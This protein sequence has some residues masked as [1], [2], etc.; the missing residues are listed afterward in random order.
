MCKLGRRLQRSGIARRVFC[1]RIRKIAESVTGKFP[2]GW[3][4]VTQEGNEGSHPREFV[5]VN[6]DHGQGRCHS[7]TFILHFGRVRQSLSFC[8]S[9]R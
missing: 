6:S 1:R 5:A 2:N 4:G 3:V 8:Y 9:G 7:K